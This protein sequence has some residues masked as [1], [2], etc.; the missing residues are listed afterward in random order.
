MLSAAPPGFLTAA[1]AGPPSAQDI[2]NDKLAKKPIPPKAA[3]NPGWE[4]PRP[5]FRQRREL[6]PLATT[7]NTKATTQKNPAASA[8]VTMTAAAVAVEAEAVIPSAVAT[9]AA[10]EAMEITKQKERFSC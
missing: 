3:T 8:V 10:A 7:K 5:P 6:G 9:A 2:T 1:R 4:A